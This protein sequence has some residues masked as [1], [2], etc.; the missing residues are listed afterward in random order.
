MEKLDR[1]GWAAGVS[2]TSYGVRV[3]IRVNDPQVLTRLSDYLP[4]GSTTAQSPVSERLYS[5]I[6]AGNS[7]QSNIRRLNLLYRNSERVVRTT[8]L[9]QVL[10]TLRS[11]FQLFVAGT[12]KSRTFVHAGVVGWK[13]RALVIPGR[14]FSGKS[15]LVAEMIRAGATYYSD[16]YAVLDGRGRVHPYSRPLSVRENGSEKQTEV[17]VEAFGAKNGVGSLPIGLVLVT[18]YQPG[19]MW[20]PRRLSPG[21]G[22]LA[23]LANTVS[24]R[25]QPKKALGTLQKVAARAT[26]LKGVRGEATQV[27]DSIIRIM[28][29]L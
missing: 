28:E 5:L 7:R 21:R 23:L 16:E 29:A 18:R 24:A 1:L 11:D 3:G 20:R 8:D 12:A 22:V 26:V 14:S 27:V 2:L 13:G 19:A 9:D 15:T 4:P 10:E 17:P 6:I 25:Q